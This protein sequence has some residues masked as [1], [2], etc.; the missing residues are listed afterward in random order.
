MLREGDKIILFPL[1]NGRYAVVKSAPIKKGDKALVISIKGKTPIVIKS[2]KIEPG[3]KAI[4]ITTPS[5]KWVLKYEAIVDSIS[6]GH[7]VASV[8]GQ[9]Q[10][11]INEN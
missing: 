11:D 10:E 6:K 8:R 3:D 2:Q 9:L 7:L 5:G 1:S 4:V